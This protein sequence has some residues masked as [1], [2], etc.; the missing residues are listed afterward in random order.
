MGI[1]DVTAQKIEK[2][3]KGNVNHVSMDGVNWQRSFVMGSYAGVLFS[4]YCTLLY[5]WI[6][7]HMSK[8]GFLNSLKRG[9]VGNLAMNPFINAVFFGYS[10]YVEHFF[11]KGTLEGAYEKAR[12]KLEEE[13][14]TTFLKSAALWIPANTVNFWLIP[15]HYRVLGSSIFA[16]FWSCYLSLVQ[17]KPLHVEIETNR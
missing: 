2:Y 10:T 11:L 6:D 9:A 5:S 1:G 12:L 4:P 3:R 15:V 8:G 14:V 17:H 16:V 7:R 13:Y